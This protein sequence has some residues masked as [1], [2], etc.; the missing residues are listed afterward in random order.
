VHTLGSSFRAP[1]EMPKKGLLAV[2]A[3]V[4]TWL[5]WPVIGCRHPHTT[6]P[7]NDQQTCLDCGSTRPY[8]FHTDFEHADAGI[9]IGK[10]RKPVCPQSAHQVA[11]NSVS[12]SLKAVRG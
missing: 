5:L 6:L 9:F 2:F 8:H 12:L 4:L 7:F 1:A 10:W 11:A 3:A